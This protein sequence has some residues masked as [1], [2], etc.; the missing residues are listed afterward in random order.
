MK[1]WRGLVKGPTGLFSRPKILCTI[2]PSPSRKSNLRMMTRVCHQQRCAKFRSWRSYSRTPISWGSPLS[3]QPKWSCLCSQWEEV[4]PNL[5]ISRL[6]SE[7]I[8]IRKQ[9]YH[10]LLPDKAVPVPTYKWCELLSLQKNHPPRSKAAKSTRRS[11][12]Q[13]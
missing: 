13:S 1:D 12:R 11:I 3:I 8:L 6:R 7:K 4:E 2:K 10:N 9:T 5:R